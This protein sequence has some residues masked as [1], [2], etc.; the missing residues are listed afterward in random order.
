MPAVFVTSLLMDRF[1]SGLGCCILDGIMVIDD[2]GGGGGGGAVAARTDSSLHTDVVVTETT[3]RCL[4][5][6]KQPTGSR[7]LFCERVA[8]VGVLRPG[9]YNLFAVGGRCSFALSKLST[10]YDTRSACLSFWAQNLRIDIALL[11]DFRASGLWYSD[12]N[13]LLNTMSAA[14]KTQCLLSVSFRN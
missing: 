12:A 8:S 13:S 5:R 10:M 1:P 14:A 9:R 3:S 4:G 11:I 7:L 6:K 2:I